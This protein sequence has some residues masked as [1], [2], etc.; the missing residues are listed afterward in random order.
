MTDRPT[1][2]GY[3]VYFL[4][5]HRQHPRASHVPQEVERGV[6]P[7]RRN[8]R[9]WRHACMD[10]IMTV[11]PRRRRAGRARSV[12]ARAP[13][14]GIGVV[15][16]PRARGRRPVLDATSS[17]S[18]R[19]REAPGGRPRHAPARRA[20][21]HTDDV[22]RATRPSLVAAVGAGPQPMQ[23][24]GSQSRRQPA[25]PPGCLRRHGGTLERQS[26]CLVTSP[27]NSG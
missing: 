10:A 24:R 14:A 9:V 11:W 23:R 17:A 3:S 1:I 8:L 21:E 13:R 15:P 25:A 26:M 16:A 5:R 19:R 18:A 6:A 20:H 27:R 22:P 4:L 7:P 12:T 2:N